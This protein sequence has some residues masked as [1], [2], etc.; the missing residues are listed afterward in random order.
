MLKADSIPTKESSEDLRHGSVGAPPSLDCLVGVSF[1]FSAALLHDLRQ[2]VSA[3]L[4]NALA[5]VRIVRKEESP[6][7]PV[8]EESLKDIIHEVDRLKTLL[9]GLGTYLGLA[10]DEVNGLEVNETVA[11][12][13]GLLS[14]ECV[15]R[16]FQLSTQFGPDVPALQVSSSQITRAIIS[17]ALDLFQALETAP[18]GA[19]QIFVSTQYSAGLVKIGFQVRALP[20]LK[21]K[22]P[23]PLLQLQASHGRTFVSQEPPDQITWGIELPLNPTQPS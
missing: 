17:L 19:R 1:G 14:G 5:A 22:S 3:I 18:V 4:F 15:R 6:L 13:L 10:E 16:Q 12:A 11:K 21:G 9:Q 7:N 2:P 8:V 23:P 20:I